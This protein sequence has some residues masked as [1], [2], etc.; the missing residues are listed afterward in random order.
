[1]EE[2]ILNEETFKIEKFYKK[3]S[4]EDFIKDYV[5]IDK[6]LQCCKVCKNYKSRWSCP[7]YDFD[8][9]DY[10]EK[11]KYLNLIGYKI[12][13]KDEILNKTYDED[14][15]NN[16]IEEFFK[17]YMEFLDKRTIFLESKYKDSIGLAWGKCYKCEKCTREENKECRYK[18]DMRYSIESLGGNV[19]KLTKNLFNLELKWA[20]KGKL[21][22]YYFTLIGLL[23]KDNINMDI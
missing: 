13:F 10:W 12:N 14:K 7:P 5:D 20:Q 6:F 21:P 11:Y 4:V 16:A 1:M 22:P 15:L 3:I 18:K 8:V 17:K 23:T 9:I 19:D 2:L